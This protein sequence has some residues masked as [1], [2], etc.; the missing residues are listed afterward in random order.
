MNNRERVFFIWKSSSSSHW[1]MP[2]VLRKSVA[3]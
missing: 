1:R 3:W 2:K